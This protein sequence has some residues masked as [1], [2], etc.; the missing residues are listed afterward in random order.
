MRSLSRV[1]VGLCA[2]DDI[3]DDAGDELH[4]DCARLF[5]IFQIPIF[6][7]VGLGYLSRIIDMTLMGVECS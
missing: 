4:N 6:A 1:P 5:I 7:S 2:A 3:D